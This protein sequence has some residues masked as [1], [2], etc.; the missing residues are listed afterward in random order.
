MNRR[1]VDRTLE[2]TLRDKK[3]MSFSQVRSDDES[4]DSD[5]QRSKLVT[6]SARPL[7]TTF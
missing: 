6:T 1:T 3:E 2:Q 4:T 5:R 7:N